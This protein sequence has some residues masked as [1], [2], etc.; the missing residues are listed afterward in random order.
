MEEHLKKKIYL[1]AVLVFMYKDIR[2]YKKPV[3]G[4]LVLF[5]FD[6][7]VVVVVVVAV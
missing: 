3:I 7:F 4:L 2:S 5:N 1:R 6:V